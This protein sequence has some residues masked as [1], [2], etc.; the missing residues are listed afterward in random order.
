M[1][2]NVPIRGIEFQIKGTATAAA[3]SLDRM[4]TALTNMKQA[5]SGNNSLYRI[6]GSLKTVAD[7]ANNSEGIKQFESSI[8]NIARQES[9]IGNI[10]DYL[11]GIS[12]IDFSNLTSASNVIG[13]LAEIA[14]SVRG[15][16][17]TRGGQP[18]KP[19]IVPDTAEVEEAE[20]TVGSSLERLIDK[21]KKVSDRLLGLKDSASIS[22]KGMSADAVEALSKTQ[23]LER[24]LEGLRGKLSAAIAEGKGEDTIASLAMRIQKV[25]AELDKATESSNRFKDSL[26]GIGSA[27]S[28]AG[29]GLLAFAGNRLTAPF[30]RLRE[31]VSNATSSIKRFTSSLGRILTYRAIRTLLKDITQ[32]LKEG[33]DNLSAYSRLLNTTFHE[34][35]DSIA[36]DALYIKNSFATIAEPIINAVAPAIKFLADEIANALNLLSQFIAMLGNRTSYTRAIRSATEYG[37]AIQKA[38]AKAKEAQKQLLGIDELNIFKDVTSGGG[39]D[40]PDYASMFE[41]V[42]VDTTTFDAFGDIFKVFQD[43]WN[44][45]G[46]ATIGKIQKAWNNIK[47]LLASVGKSF[48]EVFTNGT[49]EETLRLIYSIVGNIADTVGNLAERFRVAWDTANIGTSIIQNIW[50]WQNDVLDMWNQITGATAEWAES[51]DFTPLLTSVDAALAA[52]EPL[53]DLITDGL[54]WA[55]ENVL[56]PL[57]KWVIEDAA[58]EAVTTLATAIKVLTSVLS[59]VFEVIKKIWELIQPIVKWIE[60]TAILIIE[61]IRILFKNLAETFSEKGGKITEIVEGVGRIIKAFWFLAEPIFNSLK[62]IV[63][64]VFT[65]VGN[66]ISNVI[67]AAID[68]LHGFVTTLNG[69]IDFIAGVFTGDWERALNGIKS[70]FSGIFESLGGIAKS[71]LNV[72]IS[73]IEGLVNSAVSALNG[74]LGAISK[75]ASAVGGAIGFGNVDLRIS[76]VSLPRLATGGF[77]EDGLF[78]ANHNELVGRF[79]NGRTAVA[80]NAQIVEGISDGVRD[81][82]TDVVT[83]IVAGVSQIISA[84]NENAQNGGGLTLD[85]LASALWNPMQRQNSIHGSSLVEFS[86]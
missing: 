7:A 24:Q 10:A 43:S 74:L 13:E 5:V 27:V 6:A 75:V 51:L 22:L 62:N 78:F 25:Q 23:L 52:L 21:I 57:G 79:S 58:P 71:A 2:D 9:K 3:K 67:S 73:A 77:P 32:G 18:Q 11:L 81:A 45:Y 15:A 83:A 37:D 49:G 14:S 59:S 36:T 56:L 8:R 42:A 80:N 55:F 54:A 63:G 4:T 34:S 86:R 20:E 29:R 68:V 48:R 16:S 60:D 46:Q 39:A 17:K 31:R 38:G 28:R 26:S 85:G 53:I 82:N 72:V 66:T 64:D 47:D 69:I 84:M 44:N 19:E 65:F 61:Q 70:I 40:L 1:P 35:L 30:E 41:E 76:K 12:K 33:I 50:N